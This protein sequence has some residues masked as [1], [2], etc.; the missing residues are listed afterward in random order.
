MEEQAMSLQKRFLKS[1]PVSKV[2]F[3][4]PPSALNGASHVYLVGDFNNW[5]E[6]NTP[7]ARLKSGEFKI[8]LDLPTGHNYEFRYLI[9]HEIWENDWEAD[10]YNPSGFPGVENS[11]V[12]V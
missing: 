12:Q 10:S 7:M 9:D 3:R 2:T 8:T 5:D 4:M 1:K 11:V 6:K